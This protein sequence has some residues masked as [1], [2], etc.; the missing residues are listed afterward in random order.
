ME[1]QRTVTVVCIKK[2]AMPKSVT[3][4]VQD[5]I[6]YYLPEAAGDKS[7]TD[8]V[9]AEIF[10]LGEIF[11]PGLEDTSR[12]HAPTPEEE[13]HIVLVSYKKG[14]GRVDDLEGL[15]GGGTFYYYLPG[16]NCEYVMAT[17]QNHDFICAGTLLDAVDAAYRSKA[18]G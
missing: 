7:D 17:L 13:V 12:I 1:Q 15:A 2:G 4:D 8:Q 6:Y 18:D 14:V 16:R 10:E 3:E 5:E 9:L 11:E